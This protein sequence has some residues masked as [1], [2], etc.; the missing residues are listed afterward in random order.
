MKN[1]IITLS[2][3]EIKK[4]FKRF[5]S[6]AI[7][8]FLGV[9]VFVGIKMAS[10]DMMTS[11]DTYYDNQN[12][13]DV[14]VVS[15]L[16]LTDEDVS[17]INEISE[18]FEVYGA[19]FKDIMFNTQNNLSSVCK[20]MEINNDVNKIIINEGRM[21]E[22]NSEV[23]VESVLLKKMEINIG[24]TIILNLTEDD[25]TVKQKELT[26]VGTVTSPVYVLNGTGNLNR[27]NTTLG[28][29]NINFYAY[30][31]SDFFDMD[32]YTEIYVEV[33]NDYTTDSEE[34]NNLMNNV[35][36]NINKIKETRE[37]TR[38]DKIVDKA[39]AKI[40]EEESKV[41]AEFDS[42]K[43]EL[44]DANNKLQEA[45]NTLTSTESKLKSGK[46]A[47]DSS[48]KQINE[49]KA[50]IA[51]AEKDL[52]AGKS[53]LDS[54]KQELSNK[55]SGYG[56]TY[57]KAL[58]LRNAK[59][60]RKLTKSEALSLVPSNI[61]NRSEVIKYI[62][63]L[64]DNNHYDEL[65]EFINYNNKTALIR[66]I[67]STMNNYE[68]ILLFIRT[69]ST[70][71][72]KNTVLSRTFGEG[73]DTN[74]IQELLNAVDKIEKGY[75]TYNKSLAEFNQKKTQLDNGQKEYQKKLK[76]YENGV[77]QYER[78][79]KEYEENLNLYN[80]SLEEYNTK[81]DEFEEEIQRARNK[82]NSIDS[83]KWYLYTRKDNNDYVNFIESS[84]SIE[85]LSVIF[86]SIFFAV[87]IFISL[88]SMS[89]MAI[90]DRTEIGTLK[91]LGF[92]NMWIRCKYLI[93]SLLATLIGGIFGEVC[94][95]YLLPKIIFNT[96]KMMFEVPVFSYS[97][98]ILPQLIGIFIS[99]ICICGAT[100][101]TI[102]GLVKERTTVLLRP[103]APLK[104]KKIFL[105]KIKVIW[106]KIS[107][108][109]K[110]TIRN[111]F[112]YKKRVGM[113]I[114]GIV[115]CTTLLL[116]GYAIRDSIVNIGEK[117]FQ[118]VFLIDNIVYLNGK[119]NKETL[120]TIF[121]NMHI[122]EKVYTKMLNVQSNSRSVN[123]IVPND[124]EN[125]NKVILLKDKD[126]KEN[127]SLEDGKVIVSSKF[128]KISNLKVNDMIEFTDSENNTYSFVIS[129]ITQ[130]Y[131]G[132]YIY[133]NK[134]TYKKNIGQFSINVCYMKLDDISN[135]EEVTK[136]LLNDNENIL[137]IISA[138][139]TLERYNKM[140]SSL[141]SIVLIL[142]V[143]AGALSFVVL[144]NLTYININERQREIATL[145]VLG[146]NE[147][148][149][150]AYILKEEIIITILGILIGLLTGTWFG[151]MIVET[152]EIDMVEFIKNISSSSY[153][154]CFGFMILFSAIVNIRVHFTLKKI[155]MIESLKS[156]E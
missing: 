153:F 113:T 86:P 38:F 33:K 99:V 82:A 55:L 130:N 116:S 112:R 122:S 62:N 135:E 42:A 80:K 132:N 144:Y 136:G 118:E 125:L 143:F 64:Y 139:G 37:K 106:S 79:K 108:L 34:Y 96:Y 14:K 70:S 47:L 28:N 110:I 7:L 91:S 65:M 124:N 66:T 78:G 73:V 150:D 3:R 50:Q 26:I 52:S 97:N 92:S 109:N 101:I 43:Q 25:N 84:E 36:E 21:P 81:L 48:L 107:F 51:Q 103:K 90:E 123:L 27:G 39:N 44:D 111:I 88:L 30:V 104:G 128:A 29:G 77:S 74:A 145:K 100:I 127:L 35:I 71:K 6:L 152:I 67:P 57:E 56:L 68:Q 142:V 140:F 13:Y 40:D 102:N 5:F 149:V 129:G 115:G 76:E 83:A 32:Y 85:R 95:T 2:I 87:A 114:I 59:N 41:R 131:V 20:L 72:I 94:G 120:D 60:G 147:K 138:K 134:E 148:E 15:T 141:D 93:Y 154:I 22:N 89:R 98:Y 17:S 137:S 19:H 105:E 16:G 46:Q 1:R 117:Q 31:L 63:N 53:T 45:Q 69:S 49:G 23:V 119:E 58:L 9:T 11:L 4:S 24:D 156:I 12:L 10:P 133:M 121:D 126:T 146:F 155:D 61:E 54:S 8:S 151:H 18:D 75:N